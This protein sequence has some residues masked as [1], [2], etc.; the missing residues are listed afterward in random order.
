MKEAIKWLG[1]P[2]FTDFGR[3]CPGDIVHFNA[4][5]QLADLSIVAEKWVSQ[6][7]A[8]WYEQEVV[9]VPLMKEFKKRNKKE[10]NN[11]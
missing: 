4:Y 7:M 11:V 5:P 10:V 8:E 3:V 2:Q 6:G 1:P 9:A